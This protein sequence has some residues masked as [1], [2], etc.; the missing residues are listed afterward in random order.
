MTSLTVAQSSG[1]RRKLLTRFFAAAALLGVYLLGTIG[2]TSLALTTA[3][4]TSSPADAGRRGRGRGR[5]RGRRG[6]RGRGRGGSDCYWVGP[7]WVCD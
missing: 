6:R 5:G 1:P 2:V 3:G 4:V 7:V